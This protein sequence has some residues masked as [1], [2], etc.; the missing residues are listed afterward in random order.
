MNRWHKEPSLVLVHY[1][2]VRMGLNKRRIRRYEVTER[3]LHIAR[4]STALFKFLAISLQI[5]FRYFR[6]AFINTPV[7]SSKSFLLLLLNHSGYMSWG[8][9]FKA[10]CSWLL[11]SSTIDPRNKG[12]AMQLQRR[13]N[14]RVIR[15]SVICTRHKGVRSLFNSAFGEE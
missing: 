9:W 11:R 8:V 12:N 5:Q 13:L 10:T 14:L 2:V 1:W 6:P 7:Y 15:R 3:R 4:R